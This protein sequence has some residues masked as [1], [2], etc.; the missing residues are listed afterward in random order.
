L[1]AKQRLGRMLLVTAALFSAVS[2]SLSAAEP[3]QFKVGLS[4]AVNTALAIWM[5]QDA[6]FYQANSLNAEI[7]NMNG[8][9]RGAAELAAGR[10][11]AMHV[12]LSSVVRLN[13]SGA[14]LRVIAALANV[15]RFTFFSARGV[16]T[17]ADLKGGVVGV[18]S[19][20]SESDAIATLAL[21]R[22]GLA[23]NDVT[24]KEYG[25]GDRRL[26]A[27]RSG[28]IKA[29]AVNEPL[30]SMA[31]EQGVHVLFDLVPERIPWLFTG[32]VVKQSTIESGR[33]VLT[34]FIRATAEGNYLALTDENR[35]KRVLAKQA[36]ITDPKI[37]DISY[38]DFKALSPPNIEPTEAAATNVLA[39]FPDASSSLDA[40]LDLGIL[41]GLK[42]DGFFTTLQ[43]KYK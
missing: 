6:G 10:L 26:A 5:A 12:G 14:D 1:R 32:I 31:R 33:D 24:L 29:T 34:R 9:S 16:T 23:R 30:T 11:D 22:L 17:G 40:Y 36:N 13:K 37:L 20:G 4:E 39:Q 38:A 35:A 28:E 42:N 19:F 3:T 25:G 15:I 7:I 41:K 27:L 18:S 43:Q 21:Q 8:G 2:T